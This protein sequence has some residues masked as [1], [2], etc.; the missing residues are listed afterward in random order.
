MAI[1]RRAAHPVMR[2]MMALA[3]ARSTVFVLRHGSTDRNR[4]G[5]GMD[6]VRGHS[7]IPMTLAGENE[8]RVTAYQIA[9]APIEVV[10]SSDLKR[11][12]RSAEIL[13]EENVKQ[14]PVE[15]TDRLRSWDM[16]ASMEGKVTTPEVV[17][18][19]RG[20]VSDD[21]IVPPGGESFRSFANRL[22]GY[23]EPIFAD[24]LAGGRTIA[25]VAH[26]RCA[27]VIDFWVAA[28]CDEECMHREF[29]E[30]LAEEPDT[31]PPGGGIHYK[32]DGLGWV[33]QVIPTGQASLGTKI[34]AGSHV[35]PANE[36]ATESGVI[37]S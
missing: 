12:V 16:G 2:A 29:S 9:D 35:R 3:P 6:Q 27:Q 19:I 33:G 18:Q 5:V 26:G 36:L 4:G 22:L 34:A 31:V 10:H 21:G 14:P 1:V 24:A 32:H 30:W 25:I 20:W 15:A 8:V 28:G 13:S 37:A 23:V 17:Q 7:D 11:A